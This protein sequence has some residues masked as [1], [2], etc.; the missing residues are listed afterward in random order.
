MQYSNNALSQLWRFTEEGYLMS[1]VRTKLNQELV[2]TIAS[3]SKGSG[4][5]LQ[6]STKFNSSAQ[7]W[8]MN[9]AGTLICLLNAFALDLNGAFDVCMLAQNSAPTQ[10]W[11]MIPTVAKTIFSYTAGTCKFVLSLSSARSM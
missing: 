5:L 4:A 2:L 9:S 11:E 6:L 8:V 10:S 3:S 7:K 1:A